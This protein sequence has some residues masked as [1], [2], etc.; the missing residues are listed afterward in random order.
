MVM[1]PSLRNDIPKSLNVRSGRLGTSE[2]GLS[3]L[4][5]K[6]GMP[7][8]VVGSETS[9]YKRSSKKLSPN[10]GRYS[11]YEGEDHLDIKT[12][13]PEVDELCK[14]LSKVKIDVVH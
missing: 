10:M 6:S 3:K 12:L 9:R 4:I 13:A 7:N 2:R 8:T 5:A 11:W 1:T 14:K